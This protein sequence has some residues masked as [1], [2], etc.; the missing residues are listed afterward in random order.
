MIV[1]N[2]YGK[3]YK[4]WNCLEKY[5]YENIFWIDG[6]AIFANMSLKIT[7]MAKFNFGCSFVANVDKGLHEPG[8]NTG[9]FFM[10]NNA[11]SRHM[12]MY[13]HEKRSIYTKKS[14]SDQEALNVYCKINPSACCI[15]PARRIQSIVRLREYH[16]GDFIAHFTF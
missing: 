9:A 2:L 13:A 8:F 4:I 14:L 10:R 7:D 12:L 15:L 16:N 3:L 11:V 5:K 6:D 1:P